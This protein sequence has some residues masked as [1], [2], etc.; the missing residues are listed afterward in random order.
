MF[1][2]IYV[3]IFHH[4]LYGANDFRFLP[5]FLVGMIEIA[6]IEVPLFYYLVI[7]RSHDKVATRGKLKKL[8]HAIK[9]KKQLKS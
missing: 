2:F 4:S 5:W 6:V 9:S 1:I 3:F 8:E 7:V